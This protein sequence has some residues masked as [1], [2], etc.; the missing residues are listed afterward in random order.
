MT[1]FINKLKGFSIT[2]SVELDNVNGIYSCSCIYY[3][4]EKKKE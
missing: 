1:V 2:L 3:K 4:I